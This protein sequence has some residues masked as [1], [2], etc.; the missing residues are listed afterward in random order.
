M[1]TDRS[2]HAAFESLQSAQA[3]KALDL[4]VELE[5]VGLDRVIA[6]PRMV[7]CGDQS[8]GKSS[9][10]EA[11]T[12]IPFPRDQEL[13]TRFATEAILSRSDTESITVEIG[14][15]SRRSPEEASR[16]H[17]FRRTMKCFDELPG[18]IEQASEEMGLNLAGRTASFAKDKLQVKI[19]GPQLPNLAVVDLPGLIHATGQDQ[20]ANDIRFCE[21]LMN[22]YIREGRTIVLAVVSA[23]SD[24]ANQAIL[25]HARRADPELKRTLGIITKPDTVLNDS[26]SE[27]KWLK[28][29][30]NEEHVFHLGWHVLKNRGDDEHAFTLQQRHASEMAFFASGSWAR[31]EPEHRGIET[32]RERLA[33]ILHEHLKEELPKVQIE[34]QNSLTATQSS[35]S[36]LGTSRGSSGEQRRYINAVDVNARDLIRAAV[37][38]RLTYD[39]EFFDIHE[40]ESG[41][42]SSVNSN[43]PRSATDALNR[44]FM[45]AMS[46]RGHMYELYHII[47]SFARRATDGTR[48]GDEYSMMRLQLPFLMTPDEAQAWVFK[49]YQHIRGTEFP[50]VINADL[51]SELFR[52]QSK[53]WKSIAEAHIL[54][55][56][57]LIL[58]FL[59]QALQHVAVNDVQERL[60]EQVHKAYK[61]RVDA[62]FLEL[63]RIIEDKDERAIAYSQYLKNKAEIIQARKDN[64]RMHRL[65]EANRG[66]IETPGATM[67][68]LRRLELPAESSTAKALDLMLVYYNNYLKYFIDTVTVQVIDRHLVR[69]LHKVLLDPKPI[70]QLTDEEI[71]RL[72]KEPACI[73]KARE[74]LG[75]RR[76]LLEDSLDKFDA[77]MI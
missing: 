31:L 2:Q 58:K 34:I 14:P 5:K 27:E 55:V 24:W 4:L 60:F 25:T 19:C 21:G 23:K 73:A 41:P 65:F 70:S 33:H 76:K 52:E 8:S 32:L 1:V 35:I 11:I 48:N 36:K 26:R 12:G 6:L 16:L 38:N 75:E 54:N 13:C 40:P 69:D 62:A 53:P 18:V 72:A 17:A 74:R 15:H 46:E 59:R 57:A 7:V 61:K 67:T 47:Y 51:V 68:A 45:K 44:L 63:N 29:A 30:R 3:S 50:G 71:A 20:S 43:R 37:D 49:K 9:V 39:L 64:A 77:F 22:E 66:N 28:I 10:L 56:K 42:E